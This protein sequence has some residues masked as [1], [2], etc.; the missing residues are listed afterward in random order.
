MRAWAKCRSGTAAAVGWSV[1]GSAEFGFDLIKV[2]SAMILADAGRA[3][4]G[5]AG[6]VGEAFC[7]G[8]A[9]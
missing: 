9:G 3:R 7:Q 4:G 2:L 6:N 8:L 1:R 5:N